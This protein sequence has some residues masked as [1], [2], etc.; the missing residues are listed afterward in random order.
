M[1]APFVL[2]RAVHGGLGL[3]QLRRLPQ[4]RPSRNISK[5]CPACGRRTSQR[6]ERSA[7]RGGLPLWPLRNAA[8]SSPLHGV[9][10]LDPLWE[11]PSAL[12]RIALGHLAPLQPQLSPPP[13]RAPR[14]PRRRRTSLRPTMTTRATSS[15]TASRPCS[16][17]V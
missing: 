4:R 9:L 16:A 10:V 11:E 5:G 8:S 13:P 2:D 6:A 17:S 3:L 14:R 1:Q 12:G 15:R 7:S